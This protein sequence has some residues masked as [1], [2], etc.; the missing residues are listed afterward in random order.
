MQAWAKGFYTSKKWKDC[1][2]A[3][4]KHRMSIDGGLCEEC[5]TR[6]GYIVHHRKKLTPGNVT[7]P[8][9]TLRWGNLELVCKECHDRF[10]DHGVAPGI[11]QRVEFDAAGEPIPPIAM[12]RSGE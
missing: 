9:I 3:Y 6:P 11:T 10:E 1:R 4:K 7:D 12:D 8:E 2:R 5:G